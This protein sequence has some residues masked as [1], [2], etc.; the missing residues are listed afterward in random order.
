MHC[1]SSVAH[2]QILNGACVI[3]SPFIGV[4]LT[5]WKARTQRQV[6]AGFDPGCVK[7]QSGLSSPHRLVCAGIRLPMQERYYPMIPRIHFTVSCRT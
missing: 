4:E 3:S 1:H 2:N 6:T 5:S 7:T